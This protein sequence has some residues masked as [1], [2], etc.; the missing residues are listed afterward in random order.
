[1]ARRFRKLSFPCALAA[2]VAFAAL[3]SGCAWA[4][5]APDYSANMFGDLGGLREAF[6]KIGGTL[7]ATETSEAFANPFGGLKPGA[8]YDGLTTLT[9]QVDTKAALHWDG[10]LFNVSLLNLHGDNYTPSYIGALQTI[11]GVQGD[12]ATRLWEIWYDQKFGDQFDLRIGQQS[13]DV[14]FATSPSGAYL[15]NSLFGWPT[16]HALDMPGGGPA[17]PLASLGARGRWQ[18]GPWTALAGVF[19][20]DPAPQTNPDPQHA[21]P[22]GLS[23]PLNGALAIAEAQYAVGQGEGEY[24]GVYKLGAWYDSLSFAD[25]RYNIVGEP[26]AD[27]AA[28]PTPRSHRGDFGVYALGDQTV[29]RGA[30]K[31]RTLNLFLRPTFAPQG[32][33]NLVSF[34][35]NGGLA[36]H[37]PLPGRKND[38]LALG[39][40]YVRLSNS[41]IGFSTDS[42]LYNPTVFTPVRSYEAVFEA[43]YQVQLTPYAQLQPDLQYVSNPGGG[44]VDPLHPDRKVRDALIGGLRV[45]LTF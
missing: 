18:S 27:P 6:A 33:R 8:D 31:E 2:G 7:Q 36:L 12:R 42:A 30:E 14:E 35:V 40:G 5:D 45:N 24:A 39:F 25:L 10:G 15:V 1:M 3:G 28:D 37:D 29:W 23:F 44:V 11:S 41:A 26:L 17:F 22:Y 34:G 21:N 13:L 9:V 16:L 4:D 38:T 43:T 20:G 32:D 19:S